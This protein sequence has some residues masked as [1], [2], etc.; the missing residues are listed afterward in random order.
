[1]LDQGGASLWWLQKILCSQMSWSHWELTPIARAEAAP[2]AP[3][4]GTAPNHSMGLVLSVHVS[5]SSGSR[6]AGRQG[7]EGQG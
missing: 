4:T 1:M 6:A 2:L 7:T 5:G 3:T